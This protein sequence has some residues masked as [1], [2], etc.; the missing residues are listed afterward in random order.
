MSG[1]QPIAT[2]PRDGRNLLLYLSERPK[3]EGNYISTGS[4]VVVGQYCGREYDDNGW[5]CGDI[6]SVVSGYYGDYEVEAE[7]LSATH[8]KP[9]PPP[10]EAR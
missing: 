9:L 6:V 5:W 1:W 10:P 4:H 2:A 7:R 8:W 3:T